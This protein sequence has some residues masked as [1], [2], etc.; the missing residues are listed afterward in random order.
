MGK[1]LDQISDANI[2]KTD[3]KTQNQFSKALGNV[4]S[5]QNKN[6][7]NYVKELFKQY[8]DDRYKGKD[9][10]VYLINKEL[11]KRFK[12]DFSNFITEYQKDVDKNIDLDK[13]LKDIAIKEQ[14][15]DK[16]IA[17]IKTIITSVL[18]QKLKEHINK[19][20]GNTE[21][22][23]EIKGIIKKYQLQTLNSREIEN[24]I[25][26]VLIDTHPIIKQIK[27]EFKDTIKAVNFKH[28]NSAI[29]N[30]NFFK[31][32][33]LNKIVNKSANKLSQKTF[34][35]FNYKKKP[36]KIKDSAGMKFLIGTV[37]VVKNCK[38]I[39]SKFVSV[40]GK[41]L[42]FIGKIYKFVKRLV[43][44]LGMI[45][46]LITGIIFNLIKF[47]IIKPI[48]FLIIKPLKFMVSKIFSLVGLVAKTVFKIIPLSL[49]LI[50]KVLS[51]VSNTLKMTLKASKFIL[52]TPQGM[53]AL[54]FLLG[55]LW[56]KIEQMIPKLMI[57]KLI[58]IDKLIPDD[59]FN[60][61]SQFNFMDKFIN[62]VY[63]VF[64]FLLNKLFMA[65][66]KLED[67]YPIFKRFRKNIQTFL[68]TVSEDGLGE[69]IKNL[70]PIKWMVDFFSDEFLVTTIIKLMEISKKFINFLFENQELAE[71]LIG[72]HATA[73]FTSKVFS[74]LKPFKV[75]KGG[76]WATLL[77][78]VTSYATY[79]ATNSIMDMFNHATDT[80]LNFDEINSK[81]IQN[82]SEVMKKFQN[83]NEYTQSFIDEINTDISTLNK[84][85]YAYKVLGSI[86]NEV[87]KDTIYS[88]W[89]IPNINDTL[90]FLY[91]KYKGGELRDYSD[92]GKNL[93]S[94]KE[95]L[96]EISNFYQK[97][98]LGN[99]SGINEFIEKNFD[100]NLFQKLNNEL[101]T[102]KYDYNVIKNFTYEG[103]ADAPT[104]SAFS[105]EN[106][107]SLESI[108][109]LDNNKTTH[110][111]KLFLQ[112]FGDEI[113]KLEDSLITGDIFSK[114]ET[115]KIRFI[116][117]K[118][119]EKDIK[120]FTN[121]LNEKINYKGR[122]Y[123]NVYLEHELQMK[124][125]T[126]EDG[127][128][129]WIEESDPKPLS[130]SELKARYP[131][132]NNGNGGTPT[133]S[134]DEFDSEE[135]EKIVKKYYKK[136]YMS[137]NTQKIEDI[138][139]LIKY[140]SD[141]FTTTMKKIETN[142]DKKEEI[143]KI[144]DIIEKEKKNFESIKEQFSTVKTK[145][146]F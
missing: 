111:I 134:Y 130:M 14:V 55:F 60:S 26:S 107:Q 132:Y 117:S 30:F 133:T 66:Y 72:T 93:V 6:L 121:A 101:G 41:I 88:Y 52:F 8:I 78:S 4:G 145:Y 44:V 65:S 85:I 81:L 9:S 129:M 126:D 2:L 34:T 122:K 57:P 106:L 15:D 128:T 142:K 19:Q 61:N 136:L 97:M 90:G 135:L 113:S 18:K 58:N 139:T 46:K 131:Y 68:D 102:F 124:E 3:F 125:I 10:D 95:I 83:S 13:I 17:E 70:L 119:S 1:K 45:T 53:Y 51:L 141:I 20:T 91:K 25:N 118:L 38:D 89:N 110:I 7:L 138:D 79:H 112:T 71:F 92:F 73:T 75:I 35:I 77:G 69:A 100:N 49:N 123:E 103:S 140:I 114:P 39:I 24:I 56:K 43:G 146:N 12:D 32:K 50:K 80:S 105:F 74:L 87:D 76:F 16:I 108:I 28:N 59:I 48:N 98:S 29:K 11:I 54:G 40:T 127:Y 94:I 27:S 62:S 22:I 96:A 116:L 82:K 67:K 33:K 143:Q 64:D 104:Q 144:T 63:D 120:L 23:T 86:E 21:K 37:K 47:V 115:D 137:V 99:L 84:L 31:A 36:P 42:N 109:N 5:S